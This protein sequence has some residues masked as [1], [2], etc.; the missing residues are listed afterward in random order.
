MEGTLAEKTAMR[1]AK[2]CLQQAEECVQDAG[3]ASSL[4]VREGLLETAHMWRELADFK[5]QMRR[6]AEAA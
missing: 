2:E 4:K 6:S 5:Q 1:S 3:Q